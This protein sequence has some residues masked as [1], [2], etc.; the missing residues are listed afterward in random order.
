MVG[1]MKRVRRYVLAT[2][3][4]GTAFLLSGCDPN[5]QQTVEDGI[6]NVSNGFLAALIRALTELGA[7]DPTQT[8][9]V[10]ITPIVQL[11]T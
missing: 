11:F 6:I 9:Q 10:M 8:S 5:I 1:L 7:E 2:C 4:V 3:G